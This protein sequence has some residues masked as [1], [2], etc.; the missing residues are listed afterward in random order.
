MIKI[1]SKEQ[2]KKGFTITRRDFLKLVPPATAVILMEMYLPKEVLSFTYVEPIEYDLNPLESY[3][4]RDWEGVYR[5]LYS[6]DSTFHYLCAPND[7]HGCL[8]NAKMKNGVIKWI[9]PSF[10]YH[11]ATDLYGNTATA[12][13]DPRI[14]VSGVAYLRRFYAAERR[15]K[16]A[17]IRT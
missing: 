17:F 16:G 14:C 1:T 2:T 11:K 12:R 9:D 3:P 8:L 13:W 5:D 10:G 4:N 7:T 15:V 6:Y